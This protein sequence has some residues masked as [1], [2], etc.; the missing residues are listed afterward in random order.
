MHAGHG[1]LDHI[2]KRGTVKE[3]EH[4]HKKVQEVWSEKRFFSV[5]SKKT[6]IDGG[7]GNGNGL[8]VE[9]LKNSR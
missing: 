3:K 6:V 5:S 1:N 7:R 4:M 2:Q 9:N 8:K